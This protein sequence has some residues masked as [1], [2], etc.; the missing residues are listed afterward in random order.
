[1]S[2]AKLW[3]ARYVERFRFS[4]LPLDPVS[5]KPIRDWKEYQA[6]T[7]EPWEIRSWPERANVAI[8]T[9]EISRL[10]VV[11]CESRDDAVW[12]WRNKGQTSMIARS[13]RGIHLY[14]RH[15]GHRIMN[16][17]RVFNRYDVRGDG[18]YVCAPPS[19][20]AAGSYSWVLG[21]VDQQVLPVF[22]DE[23]RPQRTRTYQTDRKIHHAEGY[24]R[25]IRAIAG[26][27]GHSE[28]YKVARI[29][30][31]AGMRESEAMLVIQQWNRTNA[32]PPW[33]E[34]ELLHKI[35]QAYK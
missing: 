13:P 3:A 33:S 12:F 34:R 22:R 5:R 18:G 8:V 2:K 23:W 31:E 10:V 32:E 14:F 30:Q 9:G 21:P 1:M 19:E 27:G 15:P 25:K 17:Q 4:V 7:P 6:R 24:I 26:S 28:T 20:R 16:D 29:L 35:Q 11:D